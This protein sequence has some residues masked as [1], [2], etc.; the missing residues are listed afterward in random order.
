MIGEGGFTRT[1]EAGCDFE[2][3]HVRWVDLR[4]KKL[5]TIEKILVL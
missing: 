5:E 2:N 4:N 1:I 3:T